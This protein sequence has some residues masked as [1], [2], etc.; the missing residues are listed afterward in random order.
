VARHRAGEVG[1]VKQGGAKPLR[2]R[3]Y[4]IPTIAEAYGSDGII[5]SERLLRLE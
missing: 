5:A 2:H 3:D 4:A 1:N